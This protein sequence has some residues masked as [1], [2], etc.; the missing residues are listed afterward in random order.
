[1][2]F[3]ATIPQKTS[4]LSYKYSS[5]EKPDFQKANSRIPRLGPFQ[6]LLLDC[7]G[8]ETVLIEEQNVTTQD[9]FLTKNGKKVAVGEIRK[10]D[11]NWGWRSRLPQ[12]DGLY[13]TKEQAAIA[14]VRWAIS[15]KWLALADRFEGFR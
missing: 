10:I 3:S 1:M 8:D 4:E 2:L 5:L 7:V 11:G 12:D 9:V 14:Y 15:T 13:A 6:S